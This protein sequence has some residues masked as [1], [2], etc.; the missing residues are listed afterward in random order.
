M[1]A[2]S[3]P[4]FMNSYRGLSA[5]APALLASTYAKQGIKYT[6]PTTLAVS[7]V[8]YMIVTVIF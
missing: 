5:I 2:A 6:V 1:N 3:L 4:M 8:I 7:F